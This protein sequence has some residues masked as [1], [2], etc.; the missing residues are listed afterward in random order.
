MSYAIRQLADGLGF[1]E[2]PMTL[3]SGDLLFTD[4]GAG[5]VL[6]L[7]AASGEISTFA[8]TAGGANG[9]AVG[10]DGNFYMCNNG[11]LTFAKTPEG[12][13]VFVPG[14][15]G[16]RPI[17]G[18]IQRISPTGEVTMLYSHCNG[19][20]LVAPNDLVFDDNGG[21][22]FTDSGHPRGRLTDLGG[23]YYGRADGSRIVELI[24]DPGPHAPVTQPNGCGLSPDGKRLYVAESGSCRLWSWSVDAPG[25]ID[26]VGDGGGFNGA[27]LVYDESRLAIFDS[28]AVDSAGYIC[29]G[30]LITGGISVI[31]PAGELDAFVEFPGGEPFPTNICFG[32]EGFQTAYVTASGTG[33]IYEIDW[34]R[35]GLKPNYWDL[36]K[37]AS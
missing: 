26:L 8:D 19:E 18:G 36:A 33:R 7:A 3:P 12:H 29:V 31:T 37:V 20:P 35:P 28:L 23:L 22:Y 6:R 4:V 30:T 21:F 27:S 1:V 11:G 16:D 32:G 9:L 2:G 17:Q 5:K 14:S 34:P 24:H 15:H 13:N 25:S 10:P